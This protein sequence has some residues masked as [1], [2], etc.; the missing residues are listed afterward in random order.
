MKSKKKRKEEQEER[1]ERTG[2]SIVEG[3]GEE[4]K[5][6]REKRGR[7]AARR[8]FGRTVQS[9]T[10]EEGRKGEDSRGGR[11]G[12]ESDK[13]GLRPIGVILRSNQAVKDMG[14]IHETRIQV[15]RKGERYERKAVGKY[16]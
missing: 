7:G 1:K 3:R 10:G 13:L 16:H 8:I 5:K 15:R 12:E 14:E 6:M 9:R 4:R 2:K 11:G